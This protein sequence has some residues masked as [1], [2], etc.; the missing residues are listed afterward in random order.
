MYALWGCLPSGGF[1]AAF[2]MPVWASECESKCHVVSGGYRQN[3]ALATITANDL[4]GVTII[5]AVL[6]TVF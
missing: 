1:L 3:L 2:G 4:L 5:M 6:R